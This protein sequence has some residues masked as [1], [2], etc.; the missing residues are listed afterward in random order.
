MGDAAADASVLSSARAWSA[1]PS[2][3]SSLRFLRFGPDGRAELIYGYGQTIY[4]VCACRWSV[5][6]ASVLRLTELAVTDGRRLGYEPSAGERDREL[7]YRLSEVNAS[8][9]QPLTSSPPLECRWS[10]ELSEPP[11]P[12]GLQLPYKV[13]RVFYGHG[14]QVSPPDA[15]SRFAGGGQSITEAEW[16]ACADPMAMLVFITPRA[17]GRKL[18]LFACAGCRRIAQLLTD[19][20][21][22]EAL[23]VVE[24]YADGLASEEEARQ[25]HAQATQAWKEADAK[26]REPR[27][28]AEQAVVASLGF[29]ARAVVD[30]ANEARH[31][32]ADLKARNGLTRRLTSQAHVGEAAR[33][34]AE[35]NPQT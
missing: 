16:R 32:D 6:A 2:D 22:L 19:P 1:T 14:E 29:A 9:E 33:V 30:V 27:E 20:R 35:A 23:A 11:W 8:F 15:E 12:P 18:L 5:P 28:R 13:P 17:S 24:R 4:A 3:Y 31:S 26:C 34:A 7:A 21:S 25:A 10:L